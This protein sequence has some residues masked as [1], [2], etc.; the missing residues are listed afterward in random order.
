MLLE[1]DVRNNISLLIG[2]STT[3]KLGMKIDF[4]RHENEV[5]GQV[6]KLQCNSSG[7]YCFPLSSL[8]SENVNV[9]FHI[10]N[11][12]SLSNKE[13]KKKAIKLHCQLCHAAKDRLVRLLKDS[14]CEDKRFL[15]IVVDCCENCEFCLKFK[16]PFSRPVVGFPVSDKFNEYVSMDL[17]EIK[18]GS[19]GY[20][21]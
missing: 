18:K 21:I 5:N 6:I 17:K 11:L 3:S 14:G 9:V 1:V 4:T 19:C 12:L 10:K 16:K 7:H 8:A 15:K 2:K 13:K 20:F